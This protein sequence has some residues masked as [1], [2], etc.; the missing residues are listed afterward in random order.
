MK[1]S[2]FV[3]IGSE[4]RKVSEFEDKKKKEQ[5]LEV[6]RVELKN[7]DNSMWDFM[8]API[9]QSAEKNQGLDFWNYKTEDNQIP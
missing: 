7:Q 8:N 3:H 2:G 9:K 4:E 5:S 6:I 1:K